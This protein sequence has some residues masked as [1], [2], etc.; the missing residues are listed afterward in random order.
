MFAS[1]DVVKVLKG[2]SDDTCSHRPCE[3][4]V[5]VVVADYSD[6]EECRNPVMVDFSVGGCEFEAEDLELQMPE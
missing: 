4:I 6:D 3:G 5:G 2:C 1:G